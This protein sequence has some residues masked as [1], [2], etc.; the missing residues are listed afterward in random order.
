MIFEKKNVQWQCFRQMQKTFL[1]LV[2][3]C[4]SFFSFSLCDFF[5]EKFDGA[6]RTANR[7]EDLNPGLHFWFVHFTDSLVTFTSTYAFLAP[8]QIE[9]RNTAN[10]MISFVTNL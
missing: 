4:C 7:A 9:I 1:S 5:Q 3:T 10:A 8:F 2:S 6:G